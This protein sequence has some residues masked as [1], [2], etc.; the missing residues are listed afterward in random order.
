MFTLFRMIL[1]SETLFLFMDNRLTRVKPKLASLLLRAYISKINT[2]QERLMELLWLMLL[3]L[4]YWHLT[5]MQKSMFCVHSKQQTLTG[6]V[7]KL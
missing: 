7:N 4:L 2:S 6:C 1:G 3:H 5:K